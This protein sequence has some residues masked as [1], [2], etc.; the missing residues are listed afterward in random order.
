MSHAS[1]SAEQR[2]AVQISPTT[3]RLS[4]G[5]EPVDDIIKQ[6]DYALARAKARNSKLS[7]SHGRSK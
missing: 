2:K 6:L 5:I 1:L 3:I 7:E 4:I